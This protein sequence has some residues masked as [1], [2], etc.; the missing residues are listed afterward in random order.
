MVPQ[1]YMLKMQRSSQE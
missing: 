1:K